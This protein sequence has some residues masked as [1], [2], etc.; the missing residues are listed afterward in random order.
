MVARLSNWRVLGALSVV[1]T[2]VAATFTL[3]R[4]VALQEPAPVEPAF[5]AFGEEPFED[6]FNHFLVSLDETTPVDSTGSFQMTAEGEIVVDEGALSDWIG[7]RLTLTPELIA[8]IEADAVSFI[9]TSELIGHVDGIESLDDLGFGVFAMATSLSRPEVAALVGVQKVDEDSRLV[10]ASLDEYSPFQWPLENIGSTPDG[11]PATPGADISAREAWHR[12]RGAGVLVAVIDSGVDINHP[13]LDDNIWVNPAEVCGNGV[14]DDANGFIDD[15]HGWNFVDDNADVTDVT[16]HGTHV[17][18]IIAAEANNLIGIAGVAPAATLMPIKIGGET[19]SLSRAMSAIDYAV[20]NGA[21][22][23]NA[24]WISEDP[25]AEGYLAPHLDAAREAGVLV[26]AGAGNQGLNIDESPVWPAASTHPNVLTVAAS[27]AQDQPAVFSNF[28]PGAVD[29]FAPGDRIISTLPGGSYGVYSGTSM[30]GPQVAGAAALLWSATPESTYAEVKG[31]LMDR[32]DGPNDGLATFRGLAGSDGRL[33]VARSI[34]SRLF[35]SEIVYW[36]HGFSK[37]TDNEIHDVVVQVL[38]NDPDNVPPATPLRYRATLVAPVDGEI[39]GVVGHPLT[40]PNVGE[41]TTD[42]Y[43]RAF[44]GGEFERQRVHALLD[45]GQMVPFEMSL[46]RGSYALVMEMLDVSNP[47]EP[48]LLGQASAVFF[49]VGLGEATDMP[50]GSLPPPTSVPVTVPAVTSSTVATTT[51]GNE[52]TG[53]IPDPTSTTLWAEPPT[54]TIPVVIA[55]PSV[56]TTTVATSTTTVVGVGT[57]PDTSAPS[58]TSTTT[59]TI[60]GP[61]P[62]SSSTTLPTTSTTVFSPDNTVVDVAAPFVIGSINPT[63]GPVSGG[64]QVV[65]VGEELPSNPLIVFGEEAARIDANDAPESYIVAT[66]PGPVGRVDVTVVDLDN[67][68]RVVLNGAFEY[69]PHEI[70]GEASTSTTSSSVPIGT[71][72]TTVPLGGESTTTTLIDE[73]PAPTSI[74]PGGVDPGDWLDSR[75]VTP[76]GLDFGELAPDSPL[77]G[78]TAPDWVSAI[79]GSDPCRGWDL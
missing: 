26:V 30:A 29:V 73:T 57:V 38:L 25:A 20:A 78:W 21:R 44:V 24:S 55:G 77:Q 42:A 59:T 8:S 48:Q 56:T 10:S 9:S 19:P 28:G 27:D 68:D 52:D 17:A 3:T 12:T 16:G 62:T 60:A 75:L 15:C 35:E 41:V 51:G 40:I 14:D 64:T 13:D 63:R 76:D 66:P 61:S 50:V 6:G 49:D 11:S 33:N 22:I 67:G 72:T 34:F 79:C 32:S 2:L 69:I 37:F 54:T 18:G 47:A 65:I 43:G 1:V 4:S 45:D 74:P 58:T 71:S 31:A 23:I 7:G 39:R 5:F 46:P 70:G 53:S 36:F